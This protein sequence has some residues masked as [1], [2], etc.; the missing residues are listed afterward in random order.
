MRR[1]FLGFGFLHQFPIVFMPSET[2]VEL[3][4]GIQSSYLFSDDRHE[5]CIACLRTTGITVSSVHG[6][7]HWTET[8]DILLTCSIYSGTALLIVGI[9]L[10]DTFMNKSHAFATTG[11]VTK[12]EFIHRNLAIVPNNL[13]SSFSGWNMLFSDL[14]RL[15]SCEYR[16]ENT[17]LSFSNF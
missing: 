4:Q 8:R 2:S 6:F 9:W 5:N 12:K 14:W 13:Q 15:I 11:S 16:I 17:N 7:Q 3:N 10:T 1:W